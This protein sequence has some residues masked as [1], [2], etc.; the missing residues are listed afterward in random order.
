M[1]LVFLLPLFLGGA[2]VGAQVDRAVDNATT[3]NLG[4]G[5][6]LPLYVT[7]PVVIFAVFLMWH[8]SKKLV[9]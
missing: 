9:K 3:P 4:G 7:V 2:F 6:G 8:F 1:P 5:K